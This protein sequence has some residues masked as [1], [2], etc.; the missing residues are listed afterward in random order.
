MFQNRAKC[1]FTN[2]TVWFCDYVKLVED[3]SVTTDQWSNWLV[4]GFA[5]LEFFWASWWLVWLIGQFLNFYQ[6][7]FRKFGPFLCKIGLFSDL[8]ILE[9]AWLEI[10]MVLELV[11]LIRW[12]SLVTLE[13]GQRQPEARL[14]APYA[15]PEGSL[16]ILLNILNQKSWNQQSEH[17]NTYVFQNISERIYQ[18]YRSES[19]NKT[20]F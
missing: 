17:L 19:F 12:K 2:S 6:N 14:R 5:C 9:L 10:R 18:R 11:G 7:F 1:L 20:P 8:R 4:S 3:G 16:Q 15:C 13:D